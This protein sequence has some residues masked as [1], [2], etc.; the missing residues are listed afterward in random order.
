MINKKY[1]ILG[2]ILT[3]TAYAITYCMIP[4]LITTIADEIGANYS[5]FGYIIMLQ[6][7]GFFI[8]G[9]GGGWLCERFRLNSRSLVIAGM[10][11]ISITLIASFLLK[12]LFSLAVWA[13]LLGLGGGLI[14]AFGVILISSYEKP[15]SSKLMNL[16]QVFFCIGAIAAPQIISLLLYLK[17]RW[18]IIFV[19][20]GVLI[21]LIMFVFLLL[22]KDVKPAAAIPMRPEHNSTTSLLKDGLFF[23]LSATLFMYVAVE[24]IFVC[25]IAVYFE[26]RLLCSV[27]TAALTVSVFWFGLILGRLAV[28]VIPVRFTLW[29]AIFVGG[30]VM[31]IGSVFACFTEWP[32][33]AVIMVFLAGVGAG[34][35]WPTVVAIC[36]VARNRPQFTSSVIAI[37]AIGVVA[38]SGFGAFVFKYMDLK[39][40]FP[41]IAL[42]AVIL[43]AVSFASYRK[44]TKDLRGLRG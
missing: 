31:C 40:F 36:H 34:P 6:F 26:K 7:L 38:G 21:S 20:F 24:S 33:S 22:T 43:L 41:L 4:P 44:Y 25:W 18:E 5:D 23:L 42:G 19:V 39:W 37:G 35:Y 28:L 32:I 10:L 12:G 17:M 2:T 27:Y 11:V 30:I 14:E 29:P 9:I 16:S 1:A 13:V 15:H 8:A 3:L